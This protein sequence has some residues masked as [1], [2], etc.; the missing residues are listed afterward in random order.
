ML[1]PSPQHDGVWRWGFWGVISSEGI[2][3]P[4][5]RQGRGVTS[6]SLA[7]EDTIRRGISATGTESVPTLVLDSSSFQ[8]CEKNVCCLSDPV[9][10]SLLQQPKLTKTWTNP[11]VQKS[12]RSLSF[13]SLKRSEFSFVHFIWKMF[14]GGSSRSCLLSGPQDPV[15]VR[16]LK[17]QCGWSSVHHPLQLPASLPPIHQLPRK[18][19]CLLIVWQ[20]AVFP[21]GEATA[22]LN[23]DPRICICLV[24]SVLSFL[25]VAEGEIRLLMY[26]S[27]FQQPC[28]RPLHTHTDTQR[29]GSTSALPLLYPL[30]YL[31]AG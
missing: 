3:A 6:P 18:S 20:N 14:C 15:G 22:S 21:V 4:T 17:P 13:W 31:E 29:P 5:R 8:N 19:C 9:S 16:C 2:S 25:L 30:L 26:L 27:L 23:S 11:A 28:F 12:W 1:K 24:C 10:G 7:Y